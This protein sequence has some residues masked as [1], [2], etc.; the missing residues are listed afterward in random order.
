MP[1]SWYLPLKTLHIVAFVA[2]FAGLFYLPRLF[3]Y[4]VEEG[5]SSLFLTMER[6]LCYFIMTPAALVTLC[7]GGALFS[8][9]LWSLNKYNLWLH[10]KLLAVFFLILYHLY[11]IY[12][13]TRFKRHINTHSSRFYRI[14]NEIPTLLL[15]TI[16]ALAV[17]KPS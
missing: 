16:V 14:F 8:V 1:L 15:I 11:C 4:H 9:G 6:R 12:C 10:Y 2:W 7:S 3:V 13:M 5:K 17:L